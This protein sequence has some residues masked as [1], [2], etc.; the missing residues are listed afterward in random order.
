MVSNFIGIVQPILSARKINLTSFQAARLRDTEKNLN[1]GGVDLP[2]AINMLR[3]EFKYSLTEDDY[4]KIEKE[5]GYNL[6]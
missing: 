1:G 2:G 5:V 3:G 4:K 6:H